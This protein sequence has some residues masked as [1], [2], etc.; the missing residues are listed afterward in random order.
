MVVRFWARFRLDMELQRKIHRR[1]DERC[2]CRKGN[3]QMRW[4]LTEREA[5]FEMLGP[6]LKVPIF[7]LQDDRHLVREA[8]HQMHRDRNPGRAGLEGDVKMM[9]AGKAARRHIAEHTADHSAQ[10][11]LH[12]VV[13]GNQAVGC[14]VGHTRI[15]GLGAR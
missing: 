7:M 2:D 5:D 4:H 15:G 10:R 14:I 6:N 11:L 9:F 8:L 3:M 12:D 1:I 13:I